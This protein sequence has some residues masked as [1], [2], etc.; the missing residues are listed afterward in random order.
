MLRTSTFLAVALLA[1]ISMAPMVQVHATS[2]TTTFNKTVTFGNVT[3][4][5]SGSITVDTTAKTVTG[6]ITVKAVNNTNGQIIFQKTF[7]INLNFASMG[8][9]NFVLMIPAINLLLAASCN[10][11]TSTNNTSCIVSKNPDVAGQGRVNIIDVTTVAA[12]Y[13]STNPSCDLNGDGKCD[14]LDLAIEAYAFDA[15]VF[16]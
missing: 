16:W 13:G 11:D 15:P 1:L 4:T 14:I 8:T 6:T 5:T 9:T 7:P 3:V 12:G 2:Q 10:T